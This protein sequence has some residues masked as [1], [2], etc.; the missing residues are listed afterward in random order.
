MTMRTRRPTTTMRR[1]RRTDVKPDI[2][3]TKVASPL[4]LAEPGGEFTFTYVVT[5]DGTVPVT[6]TSVTDSVIGTIAL[7]ADVDLLP[8][9]S[10]V[11]MIGKWTYTDDGVYPN[12]VTA[13]AADDDGNT[14]TA[15]ADASVEVTDTLPDISVTKNGDRPGAGARWPVHLHLRGDQRRDRAGDPDQPGRRQFG[16][17]RATG[18]HHRRCRGGCRL[19][20]HGAG[21]GCRAAS[22]DVRHPGGAADTTHEVR[23]RPRLWMTMRTTA[24]RQR[25]PR[26]VT[27]T[28]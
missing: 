24:T 20:R 26:T 23:S 1:S 21:G 3:V 27:R 17:R 28:D 15:T 2:S 10:T 13:I 11:A 18:L 16:H 25:R 9:E 19:S 8:G 14:D 4:S 22:S 5:N 6:V 12:T 7:P